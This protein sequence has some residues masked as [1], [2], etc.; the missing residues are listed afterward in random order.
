MD[1]HRYVC[2]LAHGEPETQMQAAHRCGNK[3]CVNPS[4]LY[5][6]DPKTNMADAKAHGTLVG[7]GR[8]RQRL[9]AKEIEEITTSG[10]SLISLGQRFGMDPAYIGKVRRKYLSVGADG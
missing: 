2:V 7:G 4:H 9:F 5:W 6:A 1:A 3:L 10:D 8:Y